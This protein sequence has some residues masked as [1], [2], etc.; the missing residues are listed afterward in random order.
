MTAQ[1]DLIA[2]A[3]TDQELWE[4]RYRIGSI[5]ERHFNVATTLAQ[6]DLARTQ[7]NSDLIGDDISKGIWA[8]RERHVDAMDDMHAIGRDLSLLV[9]VRNPVTADA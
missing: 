6:T 9:S 5:G 8:L 3:L 2:V 7:E 1:Y 4:L